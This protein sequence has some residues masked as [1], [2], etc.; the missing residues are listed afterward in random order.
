MQC[1]IIRD[2]P[3][4]MWLHHK[5]FDMGL[6]L[7]A[8][9]LIVLSPFAA[10]AQDAAKNHGDPARNIQSL[11]QE[12]TTYHGDGSADYVAG[13]DVY[14]RKVAPADLDADGI[15]NHVQV[16]PKYPLKIAITFDQAQQFNLLPDVGYTPRMFIGMVELHKDG[17][18]YFDGKRI[19][20]PQVQFLCDPNKNAIKPS[21]ME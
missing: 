11:C 3:C 9:L 17:S 12:L 19:S 2:F 21:E 5:G 8:L 4:L 18:V 14:G 6:R 15:G 20:Q 7:A 10:L 13:K 1:L 16:E